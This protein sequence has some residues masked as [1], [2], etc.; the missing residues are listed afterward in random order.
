[1]CS[2]ERLNLNPFR[3]TCAVLT[4]D[5]CG[6]AVPGVSRLL[7]EAQCPS[8]EGHLAILTG[9]GTARSKHRRPACAGM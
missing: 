6:A 2:Q 9:T 1:M 4:S 5:S 7:A 3:P 8:E